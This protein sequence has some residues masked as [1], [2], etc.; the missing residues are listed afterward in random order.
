MKGWLR[1]IRGPVG[2]VLTWTAAGAFVG[3]LIE[4]SNDAVPGGLPM[5]SFVDVWP[6][7]LAL[8]GFLGGVIY[9]SAL[10][11]AGSRRTQ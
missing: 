8:V 2:M 7:V 9:A 11:F 1:R 4:W 6:P 5:G 10:G 3:A